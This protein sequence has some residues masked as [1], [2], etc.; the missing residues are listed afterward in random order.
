VW[1][2]RDRLDADLQYAVRMVQMKYATVEQAAV[3]CGVP[4]AALQA[5]LSKLPARTEAAK[6]E[7]D[8][9]RSTVASRARD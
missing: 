4:L 7:K 6:P 9:L 3:I 5:H 8:S 2:A 1:D